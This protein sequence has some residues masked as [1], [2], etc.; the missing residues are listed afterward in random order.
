MDVRVVR[1][2]PPCAT[3]SVPLTVLVVSAMVKPLPVAPPVSVPVL[4]ILPC[5]VAGMV[6]EHDGTPLADVI[7]T[8]LLQVVIAATVAPDELCASRSL[9]APEMI[10]VVPTVRLLAVA[11]IEQ[12]LPKVQEVLFIVI[13]GDSM[14]STPPLSDNTS[15]GVP[16]VIVVV[17]TTTAEAAVV[18]VQEAPS[19]HSVPLIVSE[20]L[21]R[22]ALPIVPVTLLPLVPKLSPVRAD[23]FIGAGNPP[24]LPVPQTWLAPKVPEHCA[25]AAPWHRVSS[26]APSNHFNT[27]LMFI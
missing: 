1:P 24:P 18:M 19:T 3:P 14:P 8:P 12:V 25:L 4:V 11:V 15:L 22:L 23:W 17:P 26:T 27:G 20:S 21:V 16:P 2:V 9:A 7:I 6:V 5:V 10:V 13:V